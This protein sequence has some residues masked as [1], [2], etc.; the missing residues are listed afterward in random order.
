MQKPQPVNPELTCWPVTGILDT[1]NNF[2]GEG[3]PY[4]DQDC[5]SLEL[6]G[7]EP[8][9]NVI[10]FL[11]E[12]ILYDSPKLLHLFCLYIW[13]AKIKTA[14]SNLQFNENAKS[15]TY[16]QLHLTQ[17]KREQ[18]RCSYGYKEIEYS[19]FRVIIKRLRL[20]QDFIQFMIYL[21]SFLI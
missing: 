13:I 17:T 1:L 19:V 5:T 10:L 11:S 4:G 7:K 18:S 8:P 9:F 6:P 3:Q 15:L 2:R 12:M 14:L 16:F 20:N 21:S